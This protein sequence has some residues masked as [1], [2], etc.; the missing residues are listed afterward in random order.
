MSE[1]LTRE[2]RIRCIVETLRPTDPDSWEPNIL[3]VT[4][5]F[6]SY[7]AALR[8][9]LAD[10]DALLDDPRALAAYLIERQKG[11]R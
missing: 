7:D 4:A 1:P 2:Q 8:Q 11:R 3:Y 6:D 9:Q 10:V 5:E